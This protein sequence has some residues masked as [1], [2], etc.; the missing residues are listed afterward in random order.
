MIQL[1]LLLQESVQIK[2]SVYCV[3][4]TLLFLEYGGQLNI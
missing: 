1:R 4:D 2:Q 3:N